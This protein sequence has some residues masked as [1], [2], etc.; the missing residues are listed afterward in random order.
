MKFSKNAQLISLG[1]IVL[2]GT[3]V[4]SSNTL[5]FSEKENK[6]NKHIQDSHAEQNKAPTNNS[7]SKPRANDS[8]DSDKDLS[9][10]DD[11][12]QLNKTVQSLAKEMAQLQNRV[13]S[14][15]ETVSTREAG[16]K[17][18]TQESGLATFSQ[19]TNESV[20]T[21]DEMDAIYQEEVR[22]NAWASEVEST[23]VQELANNTNVAGVVLSNVEC[24]SSVCRLNW[25]YPEGVSNEESFVLEN[26]FLFAM[27][28]AGFNSS[29]QGISGDGER[30]GYFWYQPPPENDKKNILGK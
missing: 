9:L 3:I 21:I 14:L 22:D 17:S 28:E 30:V 15:S 4:Y 19:D 16:V 27:N 10:R 23:V 25:Q 20:N 2:S 7:E 11:I 1:I 12:K 8:N 5:F 24:R 6:A 26:E 18:N 29:S 13:Q